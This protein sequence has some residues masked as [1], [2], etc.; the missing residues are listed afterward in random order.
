MVKYKRY[1]PVNGKKPIWAIAEDWNIIN[2]EPTTEELKGLTV[3]PSK[4]EMYKDKDYLESRLVKYYEINGRIPQER[5]LIHNPNY[6]SFGVYVN[7]FGCWNDAIKEA[8]LYEK[9]YNPTHTCDRCGKSFNE[10][11]NSGRYPLKE[12]DENKN[13]NGKWDCPNCW[14]RYDPNSYHNT[15]KMMTDHRMGTLKDHNKILGDNGEELTDRLF[16]TKRLSIL[17]D[18]YSR[19]PLDHTNI[20]NGMFVDIAGK[21]VDLSG[22]V[23]QTKC[24]LFDRSIG[25]YGGWCCTTKDEIEK[26]FDILIFYCISKD[27]K[28]IERIYIFIKDVIINSGISIVKNPSRGV[29]WYEQSRV[30]DEY[31]LE[32][33]NK[34]WRQFGN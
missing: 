14:K 29:P 23:P 34:I 6:P 18:K 25:A 3:E 27:G 15:V 28:I 26:E 24:R 13:W 4:R 2:Y 12:C 16:G 10:V 19:L 32:K 33:T 5:D 11:E 17:Y 22:K 21:L 8:G 7:I 20:P 1:V 9:R 30:T 31:I